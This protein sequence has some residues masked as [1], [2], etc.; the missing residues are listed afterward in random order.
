MART[1]IDVDER[2]C[3]I[4]MRRYDLR[5]K[6]D[7]VNYALRALAVE[8][9]DLDEARAMRGSGWVGDLSEMRGSRAE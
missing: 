8:P 6:R 4:V 5:T 9:L 7:A 1:N 2:A 3:E